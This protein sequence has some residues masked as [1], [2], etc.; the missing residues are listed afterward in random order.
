MS[1]GRSVK[2]PLQKLVQSTI[3]EVVAHEWWYSLLR[4]HTTVR[5]R[6]LERRE[7]ARAGIQPVHANIVTIIPT[8]RRPELL[9]AAVRSALDQDVADHAVLVVSDGEPIEAV[10]PEDPRLHLIEMSRNCGVAGV[11]RNI[12]I[13]CSTSRYIAF[14][15][16]DNEWMDGHLQALL[17]A[18]D[19]GAHLAYTGV[20]RVLPDGREFDRLAEPYV[21]RTL[22]HRSY[23]DV[24]TI[25]LRRKGPVYFSRRR[26]YG[27]EMPG[28]DWVYAW[29]QSRRGTVTQVP[30]CSV[31]YLIN[32]NSY[33]W[34]GFAESASNQDL[35]HPVEPAPPA[36]PPTPRPTVSTTDD[37]GAE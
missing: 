6:I 10:L 21:R 2:R 37:P 32:P 15:D 28:E 11:V 33:F 20:V 8:Y 19:G 9:S 13:R 35:G 12:G 26:R 3:G 16:D 34:P 29:R 17:M 31:R 5:N 1:F 14:L 36:M 22:R 24:N 25:G 30:H 18:L 4:A 23:I 7:V 27:Q